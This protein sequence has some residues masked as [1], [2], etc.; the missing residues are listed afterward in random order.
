[1]IDMSRL[2][3][4]PLLVAACCISLAA[5]SIPAIGP[6]ALAQ[7]MGATPYVPAPDPA[8][9]ALQTRLDALEDDLRKATG[10]FEQLGFD[11]SAAR[12][13]AEEANAG[14]LKAE[15]DLAALTARVQ[16]LEDRLAAT[17]PAPS[18]TSAGTS[19]G[20]AG[21]AAGAPTTPKASID[22]A[23]LPQDEAGLLKE[24]RNLLLAGDYPSANLALSVYLERF[25]DQ[26]S[27]A[28]AQ[29]LL[30]ESFLYQDAYPEAAEAYV[31]LLGEYKSS[32]RAPEGLV[33]LARSMRLMGETK[34]ACKVLAQMTGRYPKASEAAKTLAATEKS[35]AKC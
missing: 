34:V 7:V 22:P 24:A 18:Q 17:S 35:R 14:R 20:P 10:R 13:T 15:A 2:S 26:P 4:R 21:S 29:Y 28:E 6:P 16:A 30:G 11:L 19:P 23:S 3:P 1:M 5:F 32:P 12:R 31:A 9:I 33:K 27:A 25:R 8:V